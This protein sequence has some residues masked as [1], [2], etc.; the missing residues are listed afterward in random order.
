ME[1]LEKRL[2]ESVKSL[3]ELAIEATISA[4]DAADAALYLERLIQEGE[5]TN[6]RKKTKD[7]EKNAR[8]A[9][10]AASAARSLYA[11]IDKDFT[12][13]WEVT[14]DDYRRFTHRME[15]L[16]S[17]A[18][19]ALQFTGAMSEWASW[20]K[21]TAA[22]LCTA[23]QGRLIEKIY[24][25]VSLGPTTLGLA[26]RVANL[27]VKGVRALGEVALE[28]VIDDAEDRIVEKILDAVLS[29]E[30]NEAIDIVVFL[31]PPE[32]PEGGEGIAIGCDYKDG[33]LYRL[34]LCSDL[35]WWRRQIQ[36]CRG[37]S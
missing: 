25:R 33:E 27:V 6:F 11:E 12:L 31:D 15:S 22:V 4:R 21:L 10:S 2:K 3:E 28:H 35:S 18:N 23:I 14:T 5:S 32:S 7:A 17:Q 24:N 19:E 9:S 37:R 26:R 20:S 1:H 16:E 36:S 34:P 29:E 13:L 30:V 8:W